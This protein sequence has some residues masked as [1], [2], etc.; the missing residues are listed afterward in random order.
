ME[1]EQTIVIKAIKMLK[2]GKAC[3]PEGIYAE[4]IKCG[5]SKLYRIMTTIINQCLNSEKV[6]D[7]WKI[8]YISSIHKKGNKKNPNKGNFSNKHDEQDIWVES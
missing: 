5:T 3:G 8:A 6:P 7:E 2:N 4:L 1:V